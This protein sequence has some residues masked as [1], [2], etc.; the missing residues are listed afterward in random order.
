MTLLFKSGNYTGDGSDPK[1][2]SGVGFTPKVVI[3]GATLG[4]VSTSA[5]C[6]KTTDMSTGAGGYVGLLSIA[7]GSSTGQIDSLNSDGFTVRDQKNLLATD[8]TWIAI[9]GTQCYTGTYVGDAVD[10]RAITGVGFKPKWIVTQGTTTQARQKMTA[11]GDSTD[12][13]MFFNN[14]A[15]AANGIQSLDTDGFTI[16]TATT[17]N[18]SGT[19]YYYFCITGDNVTS[20]TYT[21]DGV[22]NRDI[23]GLPF[24]PQWVIIKRDDSAQSFMKSKESS[25]NASAMNSNT[26]PTSNVIQGRE[27]RAFEIGTA[28]QA[29]NS[30]STY[31]YVSIGQTGGDGGFL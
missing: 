31:W 27:F 17:V 14:T 6:F 21:G 7:G 1:T 2:I 19:T 28:V 18:N 13:S 30:G 3:I 8:Y 4:A 20:G 15:S 16:G 25:S 9:G 29:N 12:T 11:S 23:L 26:A 24:I 22:D 5:T 10:N